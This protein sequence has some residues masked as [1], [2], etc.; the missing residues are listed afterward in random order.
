M[1]FLDIHPQ[2]PGHAQVI[3]KKHFRWV[4]DLPADRQMSPN[5]G[6][7]FEVAQKIAKAQQRAFKTEWVLLKIIGDEV[8]HAHMWIFPNSTIDGDKMDFAGNAKKIRV[9]LT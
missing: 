9:A 3:P 6:A 2:S 5:I 4:W 8:E 1:A 7:Y